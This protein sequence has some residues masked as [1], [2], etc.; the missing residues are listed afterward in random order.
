MTYYPP[1]PNPY[2]PP[3][4]PLGYEPYRQ[5]INP[6]AP[7]RRAAIMMWVMAGLVLLCGAGFIVIV[8][9]MDLN[10]FVARS[11]QI[12]GPEM[13]SQMK[14]AGMNADQIRLSGYFWGGAGLITAILFGV[15]G[16]FV[17]RGRMWA[18]IASIV[19]TSLLTL[20]NL[21]STVLGLV[22]AVRAGPA[23]IVG[24]C[25]MMVPLIVC[26]VLL[27]FLAQAARAVSGWRQT[28]AL[29]QSQYW[30]SM[31]QSGGTSGYG[32]GY[33]MPPQGGPPSPQ[34]QLGP[35]P[36]PPGDNPPP[37]A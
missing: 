22:F 5:P 21:C 37:Q 26:G 3:Q 18:I 31:Q 7:A 6:L 20:S 24:G 36:P 29:M 4:G 12:Y 27:Y 16:T 35:I 1:P 30:Q 2:Q 11:E 9:V 8:S 33:G 34:Q 13:A 19:V 14:A 15:F 28:Q 10:A 32:Y 17:M 25:M 23:G